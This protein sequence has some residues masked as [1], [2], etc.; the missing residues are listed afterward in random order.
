[1][2]EL[3]HTLEIIQNKLKACQQEQRLKLNKVSSILIAT[4]TSLTHLSFFLIR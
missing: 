1:M 2:K 3:T 4:L